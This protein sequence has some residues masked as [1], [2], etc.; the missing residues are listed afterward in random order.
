M[1]VELD[2]LSLCRDTVGSIS[3]L[4]GRWL[5]VHR[6]SQARVPRGGESREIV[7]A[8]VNV[9]RLTCPIEGCAHAK[10]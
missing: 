3:L 5:V 1:V 6:S 7:Y 10:E 4:P 9:T 8:K 2:A